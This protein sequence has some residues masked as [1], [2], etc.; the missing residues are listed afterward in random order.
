MQ[1]SLVTILTLLQA[2]TALVIDNGISKRDESSAMDFYKSVYGEPN[3]LEKRIVRAEVCCQAPYVPI[4]GK[5]VEPHTI[6]F[7]E[8]PYTGV[9]G[10]LVDGYFGLDWPQDGS[11]I[12]FNK[13][14][15]SLFPGMPVGV[16][17]YPNGLINNFYSQVL[18][19]GSDNGLAFSTVSVQIT[20]LQKPTNTAHFVGT[21]QGNPVASFSIGITSSGPTLVDLAG[22]GFANI[23]KLTVIGD[24]ATKSWVV[25]DDLITTLTNP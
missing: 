2:A 23:D 19:I 18:T 22:N 15:F 9:A 20:S 11:T 6:T 3:D 8:P 25:I 21:F 7:D 12:Y 4:G 14:V 5:C 16:T 10:N 24:G 13:N 17:S 1:F